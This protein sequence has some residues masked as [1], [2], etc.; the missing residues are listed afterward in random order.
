MHLKFDDD[1]FCVT[2]LWIGFNF[3]LCV[4]FR[5]L[6]ICSKEMLYFIINITTFYYKTKM[7]VMEIFKGTIRG[8]YFKLFCVCSDSFITIYFIGIKLG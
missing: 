1:P 8:N 5:I 7:L 2:I 6:Q 4:F 3:L